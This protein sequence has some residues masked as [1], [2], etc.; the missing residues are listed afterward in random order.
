MILH[1][2]YL[3]LVEDETLDTRSNV[4]FL[5]GDKRREE[6]ELTYYLNVEDF[7]SWCYRWPILQSHPHSILVDPNVI[8]IR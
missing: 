1:S 2:A 4:E 6:S 7:L 8:Q 3:E 5:I